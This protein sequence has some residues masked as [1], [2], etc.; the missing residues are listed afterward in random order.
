MMAHAIAEG[1]SSGGV[2]PRVHQMSSSHRSDV[3]ADLLDAGALL[4]GS[5]TLNGNLFPTV[6]DVMAYL[7]GLR[8]EHLVGA[9]FGSH[10]WSG[11][12]VRML[13]AGLQSMKVDLVH[14]GLAV[15]YRPDAAELEAC[16]AL[17]TAAADAVGGRRG[18]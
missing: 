4:V 1:L 5:P 13:S 7:A 17:G 16:R 2:E 10:G 18:P 14:P 8:R 12:A 3:A 11:E 15:Q 6:A 9:A